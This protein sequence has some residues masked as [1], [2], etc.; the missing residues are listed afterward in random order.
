M[1]RHPLTRCLLAAAIVLAILIGCVGPAIVPVTPLPPKVS[2]RP[3]LS[4]VI[5]EP[6]EAVA[7]PPPRKIYDVLVWNWKDASGKNVYDYPRYVGGHK[8]EFDVLYRT[9]LFKGQWVKVGSSFSNVF[10]L[11]DKFTNMPNAYFSIGVHKL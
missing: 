4:P 3:R 6:Q 1:L 9:N 8:L 5:G 10:R 2:V 7:P 11:P